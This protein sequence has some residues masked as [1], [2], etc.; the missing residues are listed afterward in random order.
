MPT[1]TPLM[2]AKGIWNG[3]LASAVLWAILW[4]AGEALVAVIA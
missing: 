3:L 2:E 1:D 4:K